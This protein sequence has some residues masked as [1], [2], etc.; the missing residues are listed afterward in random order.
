MKTRIK[1]LV[2]IVFCSY[3]SKI[4]VSN[5]F[6]IIIKKNEFHIKKNIF[7]FRDSISVVMD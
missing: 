1:S 5:I 7:V 2:F 3:Y 6:S 4:V